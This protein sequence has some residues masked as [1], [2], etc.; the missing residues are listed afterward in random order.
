MP[1]ICYFTS[2]CSKGIIVSVLSKLAGQHPHVTGHLVG[3]VLHG[4]SFQKPC[5]DDLEQPQVEIKSP[6]TEFFLSR[7]GSGKE[8]KNLRAGA[9]I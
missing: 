7:T 6:R 8:V 9:G 4:R 2:S 1:L 5:L 3:L